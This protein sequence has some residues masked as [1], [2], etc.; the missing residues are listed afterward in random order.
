VAIYA[1]TKR[2]VSNMKLKRSKDRKVANSLTP[3]GKQA[4]IGN[5]FGL[6]A[7][8]E[9]S[10]PGQTSICARICYAGKLEKVYPAVKASLMH[11]WELLKDADH[12]TMEAL[13]MEMISDFKAECDKWDAPKSFR[14]HWDG[15]FFSPEYAFVWKHVVLNHPDVQFWVYT[16]VEAAAYMLRGMENLTLYFST[17][18]EN[19]EAANRLQREGVLLAGLHNTFDEAKEMLLQLGQRSAKCPEQRKQIPLEGACIACG[20]CVDGVN[21]ISFSITK[22]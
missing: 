22:R 7:G 15:D 6:P 2:R 9:Y 19:L 12:D 1:L 18:S 8:R 4:R 3:N 5:S 11:N 17:D 21:N 14:I 16:R 20:I 10:C 13:L